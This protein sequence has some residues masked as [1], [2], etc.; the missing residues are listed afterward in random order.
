LLLLLL[1]VV[2]VVVSGHWF[3]SSVFIQFHF[4]SMPFP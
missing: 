2:V 4:F 1:F 3:P